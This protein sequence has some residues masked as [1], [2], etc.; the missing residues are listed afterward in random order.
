VT[1]GDEG[2]G[3]DGFLCKDTNKEYVLNRLTPGTDNANIVVDFV[4]LSGEPGCRTGQLVSWCKTHKCAPVP[5]S[6][7]CFPVSL[8]TGVDAGTDRETVRPIV[9]AQFDALKGKK[10]ITGDAPEKFVMLRLIATAQDCASL[11]GGADF[12]KTKLVGCAYSCPTLFT[13]A[14]QDIYLGFDTL[15]GLCE[16]GLRTCSDQELH[17][18]P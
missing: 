14:G 17:W 5:D 2:E 15:T 9:K 11:M 10:Q 16:Q 6:R 13:A 1:F 18:Q 7:I 8:P 3:L 12:D 4:D